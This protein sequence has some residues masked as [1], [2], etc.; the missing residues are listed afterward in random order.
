[1]CCGLV[2]VQGTR[3]KLRLRRHA[4]NQGSVVAWSICRDQERVVAWSTCKFPGK[5][6]SLVHAQGT[7]EVLWLGPRHVTREDLF[8]T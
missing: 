8:D 3:E 7:K 2:H 1:M 5:Y 4:T 6:C